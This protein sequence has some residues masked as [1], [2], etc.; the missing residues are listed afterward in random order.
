MLKFCLFQVI[1]DKKVKHASKYLSGKE[2]Q[3]LRKEVLD[4]I[5]LPLRL[6]HIVRNPFDNI[7]TMTFRSLEMSTDEAKASEKKVTDRCN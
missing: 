4:E 6:I 3:Q 2:W 7:A 5:D 1:G